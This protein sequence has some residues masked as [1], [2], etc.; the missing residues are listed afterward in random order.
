[1]IS[2]IITENRLERCHYAEPYAG[3]CGLA[4]TMLFRGFAHE[5]YIN[6]LDISIWSFWDS[7]LNKTEELVSL[8]ESTDVTVHEWRNQVRIHKD[9]SSASPLELG[10]ATFFLNR[11]NRSGVIKKAGVIGGLKQD[12]KYKID[13]RFN[14]KALIDKIR[15]IAKYKH[16]IHLYNL[17][18]IDFID[19]TKKLLPKNSLYCIDPPYYVKGSSLYTD[20]Y[21]HDDH[22]QLAAHLKKLKRNWLLT[23]DNSEAISKIYTSMKQFNFHLNYSVETKRIGTELLIPSPGLL[24]PQDLNIYE[25]A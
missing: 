12:G 6:D 16:R 9:R 14:K 17:D 1:M 20:F 8:I 22:I 25:V 13:C 23:Y 11:T 4:L 19:E 7:V 24:I 3:G 10:F 5:I 21:T 15:R 18:A 2:E